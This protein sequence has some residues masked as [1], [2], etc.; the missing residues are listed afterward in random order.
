M[1]RIAKQSSPDA[2]PVPAGGENIATQTPPSGGVASLATMQPI[3]DDFDKNPLAAYGPA[4]TGLTPIEDLYQAPSAQPQPGDELQPHEMGS[5]EPKPE[6]TP[7]A[8]PEEVTG[9]DPVKDAAYWQSQH[10][11]REHEHKLELERVRNEL[12]QEMI[13][14]KPEVAEPIVELVAPKRPADFDAFES[15]NNP[16]SES[17]KWRE[18]NEQYKIDLAV[19]KI[20]EKFKAKEQEQ[21]QAQKRQ[22]NI[23]SIEMK[24]LELAKNDVATQKEF[25]GFLNSP[26]S[27]SLD[28]MFQAFQASKNK[29]ATVSAAQESFEQN[30]RNNR[31]PTDP[32]LVSGQAPQIMSEEQKFNQGRKAM[33]QR[34]DY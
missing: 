19:S 12:L 3:L 32:G 29:N 4:P 10:D 30:A 15:H 11:K 6:E 25:I 24:A 20:E 26:E 22:Q 14:R 31:M 34:Q 17:Y 8:K 2:Q 33:A 21:T 28:F 18:A 23:N 27:Y 5:D 9:K 16:D 1:L 13:Q 7:T